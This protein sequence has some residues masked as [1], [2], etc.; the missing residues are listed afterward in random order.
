MV[1]ELSGGRRGTVG[2]NWKNGIDLAIEEINR[3]G[4]RGPRPQGS[5]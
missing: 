3:Q 5:R 2:T 4:R 1:A